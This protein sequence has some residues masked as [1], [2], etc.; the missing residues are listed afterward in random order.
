MGKRAEAGVVSML[1]GLRLGEEELARLLA[2]QD[3][4]GDGLG[5]GRLG[6]EARLWDPRARAALADYRAC[7]SEAAPYFLGVKRLLILIS[8][9]RK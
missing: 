1:L 2:L 4:L 7:F 6:V 5:H 8:L 9:P 3:H